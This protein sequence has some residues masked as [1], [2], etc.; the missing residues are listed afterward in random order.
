[1][2]RFLFK[3]LL[4]IL[5]ISTGGTLLGQT[6]IYNSGLGLAITNIDTATVDLSWNSPQQALSCSLLYESDIDTIIHSIPNFFSG[7]G[8][9]PRL[10]P[11]GDWER[12][13]ISFLLPDGTVLIQSILR[14]TVYGAVIIIEEDI[15]SHHVIRYCRERRVYGLHQEKVGFVFNEQCRFSKFCHT[16]IRS[17]ES[18]ASMGHIDPDLDDLEQQI[19]TI[20]YAAHLQTRLQEDADDSHQAVTSCEDLFIDPG[21]RHG[22]DALLSPSINEMLSF[23]PNPFHNRLLIRPHASIS[24]SQ[25]T[26]EVIDPVGKHILNKTFS[27]T[28]HGNHLSIDATLWASGLYVISAEI[29]RKKQ[30]YKVIKR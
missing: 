13:T 29:N 8:S 21:S 6:V 24:S 26:I 19:D 22:Q 15:F 11:I 28:Q 27:P 18:L 10:N 17:D 12:L 1:M 3:I 20:L 4:G 14:E 7:G 9:I 30:F 5:L 25:L 16:C 23:A 2:R